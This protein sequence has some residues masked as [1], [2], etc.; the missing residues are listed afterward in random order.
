[1]Q[2]QTIA[3]PGVYIHFV[4][5]TLCKILFFLFVR[6]NRYKNLKPSEI[7]GPHRDLFSVSV[8]GIRLF[9]SENNIKLYA[10]R[11]HF[12]NREILSIN[13]NYPRS[14]C[15]VSCTLCLYLT[16]NSFRR[17]VNVKIFLT[18]IVYF[19]VLLLAKHTYKR[20]H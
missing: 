5:R 4:S 2:N 10:I 12:F 1:M 6:S 3:S 20:R 9:N 7:F 13:R 16:S 8:I 11:Q 17:I 15:V 18:L 14:L 19:S